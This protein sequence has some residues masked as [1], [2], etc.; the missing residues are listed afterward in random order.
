MLS[1][2]AMIFKNGEE[3]MGD[4]SLDA[5]IFCRHCGINRIAIQYYVKRAHSQKINQ[6]MKRQRRMT[7]SEIVALC[8]T[9]DKIGLLFSWHIFS[10]YLKYTKT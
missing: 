3:G 8:K 1:A 4:A 6:D 2:Y 9:T 5:W 7:L 10:S